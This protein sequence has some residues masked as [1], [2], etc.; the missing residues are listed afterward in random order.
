MVTFYLTPPLQSENACPH[1]CSS[2]KSDRRALPAARAGQPPRPDRR[3]DRH[4]QDGDAA[5][6]RRGLQRDRRAGLHGR[7]EGRP[8]R[9]SPQPAAPTRRSRSASTQLGLDELRVRAAARSCSGTC[10]ASRATR[11]ARPSR[12]WGRCCS[13]GCSNLNDTQAG[14]LTLVFKIADDNGLLL[15]DLKDLRAMLQYVGDNASAV[16]DR[17]RQRLRRQRSARSSAACSTLEQQGGDKFFGEPALDLDDLMQTD[18]KGR[19]VVNILAADK[20]MQS[21]K[22]YATF[23]LW[24]LVGALRAAAG[25]RRSRE[26]EARLLLRRSAPALQRRAARRCSRRSSRS[27]G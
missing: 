21:P 2:P 7:R 17:V 18:G 4:R 12:R 22:L 23:L 27:C 19:G 24:L 5:G 3:R 26:A 16:H 14:V 13:R 11:C 20:L 8:R 1:R 9:A 6:A 25:S 15:L 10:S